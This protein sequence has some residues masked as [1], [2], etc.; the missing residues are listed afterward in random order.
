MTPW[1]LMH[2]T[3]QE[4]TRH[5]SQSSRGYQ[6]LEHSSYPIWGTL[7]DDSSFSHVLPQLF[8]PNHVNIHQEAADSSRASIYESSQDVLTAAA[9]SERSIWEFELSTPILQTRPLPLP[10]F[11]YHNSSSLYSYDGK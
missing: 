10:P 9:T 4:A 2:Q 1:S 5:E 7:T 3:Y 11:S 8:E 6:F